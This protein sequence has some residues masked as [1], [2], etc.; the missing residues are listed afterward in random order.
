MICE[1]I[2]RLVH[3]EPLD[4]TFGMKTTTNI[5]SAASAFFGAEFP[6][7]LDDVLTTYTNYCREAAK[8]M[9]TWPNSVDL[10]AMDPQKMAPPVA[11]MAFSLTPMVGSN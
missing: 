10:V 5:F 2:R 9:R 6:R 7:V 11:G 3:I 8:T 4:G 1:T